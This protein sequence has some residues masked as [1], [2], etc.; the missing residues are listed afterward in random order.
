VRLFVILSGLPASGKTTL[1]RLLAP[2]LALP[3]IDKDEI[4]EG[5]FQGLARITPGM[6]TE[7][8]RQSD[9]IMQEMAQAMAGAVL[10]S[11]WQHPTHAGSSGTPSSWLRDLGDR[12]VEVHCSCDPETARARFVARSRHPGHNDAARIPT[13]VAQFQELAGRYPLGIGRLI[14]IDASQST[15]VDSLV[16]TIKDQTAR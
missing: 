12:I 9:L 1:A 3:L 6:R 8:S 11:F 10:V 13:L 16:Q 5:L 7:L 2:R 4:L 14:E 15:D